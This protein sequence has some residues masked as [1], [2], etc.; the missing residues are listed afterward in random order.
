M[1]L[2]RFVIQHVLLYGK[3]GVLYT[4]Y[5]TLI[6]IYIVKSIHSIKSVVINKTSMKNA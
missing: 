2:K 4:N 6:Y 3:G 5:I 1:Y